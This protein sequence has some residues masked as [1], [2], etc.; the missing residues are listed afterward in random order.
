MSPERIQKLLSLGEG[1][2][3]EFKSSMKNAEALGRVICGL[4]NT[5]GGYLICGVKDQGGVLGV[6]VSADAI[7]ALEKKLYEGISPK[8]LVEFEIESL[9]GRTN[10][11]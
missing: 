2:R 9:D 4:L 6:D 11:I 10:L 1:Q 5:S 3:V 7:A 8:A